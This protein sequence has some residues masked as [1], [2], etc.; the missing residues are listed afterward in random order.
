MALDIGI[1]AKS[2]KKV[3][4]S[5]EQVLADTYSLY[6]K[7]HGY[8]WNIEGPRFLTL[9]TLFETQ[10]NELWLALDLIAER[11]R[12]LG[13]YA[14][15]GSAIATK[16]TI[17]GDSGVPSEDEMLANL[18]AGNEAV[19]KAA[20]AALEVAEEAGDQATADLMTQRVAIGEKTAWMLRAH[21]AK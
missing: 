5:L 15:F 12:S 11:I 19:V 3:A 9:H 17:K 10:Y 7:T 14:P 6:A 1:D 4:G 18:A 13:H 2:R 21:L 16:S 20:R 8:H